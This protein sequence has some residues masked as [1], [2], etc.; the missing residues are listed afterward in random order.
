MRTPTVQYL[1]RCVDSYGSAISPGATSYYTNLDC[2]ERR[3]FKPFTRQGIICRW[4]CAENYNL[5]PKIKQA[6]SRDTT[7]LIDCDDSL[8]KIEGF[9]MSNGN[10]NMSRSPLYCMIGQKVCRMTHE[11]Y[12]IWTT[13]CSNWHLTRGMTT[14]SKWSLRA[15]K[16][17]KFKI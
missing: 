14:K 17:T 2:S 6:L 5:V 12:R 1:G 10:G 11:N 13:V 7:R 8:E 4:V 16:I 15:A 9:H 3:G